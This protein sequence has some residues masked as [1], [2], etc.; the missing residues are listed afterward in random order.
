MFL[1]V[2]LASLV[3]KHHNERQVNLC[4]TITVA[5]IGKGINYLCNLNNP[6]THHLNINPL[7]ITIRS[8]HL[9]SVYFQILEMMN[10]AWP[11]FFMNTVRQRF[12]MI[13]ENYN[14]HVNHLLGGF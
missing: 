10:I 9:C 11:T 3:I 13:D 7:L 12:F 1:F 6:D 4:L 5:S 8:K 2:R 14:F